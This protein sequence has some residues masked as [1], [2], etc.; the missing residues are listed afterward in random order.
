MATA[1]LELRWPVLFSMTSGSSHV[2]EP[3]AQVFARPNEQYV[4]GL[5]IPNEDAQSFVFDATTLFERDKFS[6]YDRIEGGTRANVGFRY[7]GSYGNG[8]V[9]NAH[10]RPVLPARRRELVR[11]AGPGQ[12]RRLFRPRN[13]QLPTMSACS[14]SPAPNGFSAS[15]SGRFDEQTFEMRRAE[16]KAGY[17]GAAG[18]ADRQDTP[19]SRPSRSTA[20]PTTATRSRSARSTRFAENWRVFGTGTYD[21]QKRRAGPATA[22]ASPITTTA[23]PI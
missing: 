17:H 7:S 12:C 11:C 10:V 1:G 16:V 13:R 4:G 8:W 21:L 6:G 18:V 15:V 2:L 3:M 20:S 19:S 23:S 9:T 5:G 22:S 14:A